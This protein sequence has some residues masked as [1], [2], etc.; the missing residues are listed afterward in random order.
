MSNVIVL[1]PEDNVATAIADLNPGDTVKSKS[2]QVKVAEAVPFGHKVALSAIAAGAPIVKYGEHI[3]LAKQD[4][5]AGGYVH[6]HNID[7]QRGRGDL[8]DAK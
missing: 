4:I 5:A 3:G 1:H 7:S 2:A 8:G 6:I